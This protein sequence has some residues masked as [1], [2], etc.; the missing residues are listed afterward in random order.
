MPISS[1]AEGHVGKGV[2]TAIK[3]IPEGSKE[4]ENPRNS[5]S[6]LQRY[7]QQRA[8]G[9]NIIQE[10]GADVH[11]N[12]KQ[13][14]TEQLHNIQNKQES[15]K[16]SLDT[17]NTKQSRI[18]QRNT[19]YNVHKVTHSTMDSAQESANT[20]PSTTEVKKKNVAPANGSAKKSSTCVIF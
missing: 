1:G 9:G 8:L 12:K 2:D 10:K 6:Y 3:W 4:Y 11:F 16:E 20:I 15:T 19:D 18:K 7:L 14:R 17:H 5:N 13:R